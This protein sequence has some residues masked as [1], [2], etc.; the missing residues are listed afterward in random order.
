MKDSKSE[1]KREPLWQKTQYANLVRYVPSGGYYARIRIKGKLLRQSLQTK[2]LTVAKMKLGDLEKEERK[3]AERLAGTEVEKMTFGD[4]LKLYVDNG[5]RPL[6][7]KK[8]RDKV[9]LKPKAVEYYHYRT[10]A[11]K[12]LWP[13]LEKTRVGQIR[14]EAIEEWSRKFLATGGSGTAHNHTLGLLRSVFDIALERGA[15]YQNPAAGILRAQEKPKKLT[16][17]SRDQFDL[18]VKEIEEAGG[19]FSARCADLVRFLAFGGFRKDEAAHI[20]WRDCN[21]DR[22]TILVRG[23]P[24]TGTK[25]SDET[26]REVPMIPEM[27]ELLLRLRKAGNGEPGES[28]VML[29]Q[30]CQKAMD[31]AAKKVGMA[32]ITHHDLRHLFATRCIESGVDIPTLSRWLGHKDGG[33]LAMRTYGHLRDEHSVAMAQK[34]TFKKAVNVIPMEPEAAAV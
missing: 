24:E 3:R 13:D 22:G 5:Y 33:A 31:G 27:R 6:T 14:P 9:V 29:I 32:R 23:N 28:K 12:K 20:T 16:L 7:P 17:P 30:E 4:A 10:K 25:G 1:S 21:F 2:S 8:R 34:V 15:I 26:I 19:G 11:L 18:F